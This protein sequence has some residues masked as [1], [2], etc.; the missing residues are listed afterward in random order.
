RRTYSSQPNPPKSLP[1]AGTAEL[2]HRRLIYLSGPDAPKFLQGLT[3]NNVDPKATIPWYSAFLDAR[4]R[5]MWDSFIYPDPSNEA[6]TWA[7]FIEVDGTEA[8]NLFKHLRRHKLR[9]KIEIR[10]VEEAEASVWAGWQDNGAAESE[11]HS[12][13]PGYSASDLASYKFALHDPR[14][15]GFGWRAVLPKSGLGSGSSNPSDLLSSR[16]ASDLPVIDVTSYHIRRY[17]YGIPEG[18]KEMPPASALPMESNVD[19]MHGIDFRKGCYV[20]QELTIRTKHTG[21]V[22]KRILPVQLYHRT[23]GV[24]G[25]LSMASYD[26]NWR[27]QNTGEPTQNKHPPTGTDIKQ[28]DEDGA[29]KKGRATGKFLTGISNIGLALCRLEMMTDIKVSAEG[30]NWRPGMEFG[31]QWNKEGAEGE[32]ETVRIMPIVPQWLRD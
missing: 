21:I 31:M 1:P 30:G 3:T 20:G 28:L 6:S 18:P 5:M 16:E 14:A 17:L 29:A 26:P 10:L 8:D 13:S 2:F 32:H 9:S 4:G 27:L 7:C 19:L 15:P 23:E 25:A 12:S 24:S 11:P 22:R